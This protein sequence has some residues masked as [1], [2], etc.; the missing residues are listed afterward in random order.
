MEGEGG[1][2]MEGRGRQQDGVIDIIYACRVHDPVLDS[3]SSGC[4]APNPRV[5]V[6]THP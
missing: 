2:A 3:M 5:T 6:M 4:H 1:V